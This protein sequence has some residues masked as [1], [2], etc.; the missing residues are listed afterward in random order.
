MWEN[1][2]EPRDL[3]PF[4]YATVM[5]F[6]AVGFGIGGVT[7]T[8]LAMHWL[9]RRLKIEVGKATLYGFLLYLLTLL[10]LILN[11]NRTH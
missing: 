11:Y 3:Y 2:G 6:L 10:I 7:V 8:F 4:L 1:F 5:F 9:G